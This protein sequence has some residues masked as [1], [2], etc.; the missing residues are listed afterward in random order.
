VNKFKVKVVVTAL[1]DEPDDSVHF[2]EVLA[3]TKRQALVL[4]LDA[5]HAAVAIDTDRYDIDATIEQ[6]EK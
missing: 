3:R 6:G 2:F 1:Q 5:F 4:G